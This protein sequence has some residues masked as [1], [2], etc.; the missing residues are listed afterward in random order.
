MEKTKPLDLSLQVAR[1]AMKI[2][3]FIGMFAIFLVMINIYV[4][5]NQITAT[6]KMS[7]EI[8][9][10]EDKIKILEGKIEK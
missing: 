8:H 2:V 4:L 1:R 9:H 5:L 7:K 10:L 6:A 3:I